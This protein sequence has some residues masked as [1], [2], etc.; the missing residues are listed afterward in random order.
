VRGWDGSGIGSL[1]VALTRVAIPMALL[2][3]AFAPLLFHSSGIYR[4]SPPVGFPVV[5]ACCPRTLPLSVV[6]ACVGAVA[7]VRAHSCKLNFSC[8]C[9]MFH[10]C[11]LFHRLSSGSAPLSWCHSCWT[12]SSPTCQGTGV[13]RSPAS[14]SAGSVLSCGVAD[15]SVVHLLARYSNCIPWVLL[16]CFRAVAPFC[17]CRFPFVFVYPSVSTPAIECIGIAIV[18]ILGVLVCAHLD[19]VSC[20]VMAS[21]C[22]TGCL[23]NLLLSTGC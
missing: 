11:Y 21:I 23:R 17:V 4:G 5:V 20:R 9:C 1:L 2:G 12:V 3:H 8:A 18:F 15:V 13:D 14:A 7:A 6:W 10:A 22:V 19:A 16:R